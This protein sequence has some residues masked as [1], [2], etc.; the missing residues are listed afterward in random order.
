MRIFGI[1]IITDSGV[2]GQ[3]VEISH[4]EVQKVA[5]KAEPKM[6]LVLKKLIEGL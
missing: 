5:M 4:E 2:P 3:I 1:S 6:T